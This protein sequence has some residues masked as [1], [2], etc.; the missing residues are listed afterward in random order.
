MDARA[1][2]KKS[3]SFVT[4]GLAGLLGAGSMFCYNVDSCRIAMM[5][6]ATKYVRP[7]RPWQVRAVASACYNP[8][9][10]ALM[11]PMRPQQQPNHDVFMPS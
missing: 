11:A 3:S 5:E 1:R 8:P 7:G 10:H 2:K 9:S 6:E 4:T